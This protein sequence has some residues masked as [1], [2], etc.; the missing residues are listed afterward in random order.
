MPTTDIVNTSGAKV[1]V[2]PPLNVRIGGAGGG[3][4][5]PNDTFEDVYCGRVVQSAGGSRLDFAELTYILDDHLTDRE[6]PERFARVIEVRLPDADDTRIHHGDYVTET[7]RVDESGEYLTAQSQLRN[8]HFGNPL[9]RYEVWSPLA[10]GQQFVQDDVV[11]NPWVD[12][13]TL[14]NMSSRD[15][16]SYTGKVWTHPETGQTTAG[17]TWQNQTRSQWTLDRAVE[18]IMGLL[19][20]SQTYIRNP[21]LAEFQPTMA[22]APELRNVTIPIGTSLPQALDMLCIPHGYNWFVEYDAADI[23][24]EQKPIIRFFQI[25]IGDEKELLFQAPG[26]VLNLELS[27][28]NHFEVQNAIGDSFN[29]VLV[30]GAFEEVECTFPLFPGWPAAD[31][32]MT[33]DECGKAEVTYIGKETVHRL[34]IANEAGDIDPSVA[35]LGQVPNVPDLS[36]VGTG[37]KYWAPHR[38]TLQEPITFLGN[39]PQE[40]RRPHFIEYSTDGG[41]TW[42]EVTEWTVKLLPDQIGIL[43]DGEKPPE[44]LVDAGVQARVRITGCV[45]LDDRLRGYATQQA[46][47]V[48]ARYVEQVINRPDKFQHRWVNNAGDFESVLLGLASADERDD[49]T[50]IQDYAEALRDNNHY[51]QVDCDF[52]LP[53]W[54]HEYKIGDVITKIAGREIS[55]DGAP[56]TA[57]EHKYVQITERRFEDGPQGPSTVLIVDRGTLDVPIR[58]AIKSETPIRYYDSGGVPEGTSNV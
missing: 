54:H 32:A 33:A 28:V 8:Y 21:A 3:L 47:A 35:R 31:D 15:S 27:N 22:G 19:N 43:F 14:F 39:N 29:A 11:F 46:H 18:A 2:Y 13:Q 20:R 30:M 4:P 53:G 25:G 12:D 56:S 9:W 1:Y 7:F 52:R 55:L 10:G 58:P 37:S 26:Q 40:E 50:A 6:Q 38:R 49:T 44:E 42:T 16:S 51:A 34:W 45:F 23:A 48:N 17:E 57:P 36:G 24:T 41:A 5:G